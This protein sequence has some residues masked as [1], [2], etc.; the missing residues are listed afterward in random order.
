MIN[1]NDLKDNFELYLGGV[2]ILVTVV[3]VIINVFTRYVLKFTFIW[4]EEIS[5]MCF[6][7]TIFLGAVGAFKHKM[8]M[9][10]DFLLQVTKGKTRTVIEL[11][12]NL[13]VFIVAV[14]MASM[15]FIY[16]LNSKKITAALQISYTWINISI[17]ISFIMISVYAVI[18]LVHNIVR[19]SKSTPDTT[20]PQETAE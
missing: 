12:S 9:G 18:N 19:I 7:W 4:A 2:F 14:S 11:L 16:V 3:T 5:V 1:K 8:L 20:L 6:V 17:P 13:V 15:S 10:V